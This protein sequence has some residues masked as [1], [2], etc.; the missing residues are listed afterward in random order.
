MDLVFFVLLVG[1]LVLVHELGHFVAARAFGVKVLTFSLG[2]GPALLRIRGRE[3]TYQLGLL[4]FGGF[5]RLLQQPERRDEAVLPPEEAA[6]TYE[7]RS[8][9]Q[10][11]LI[12]LAGPTMNVLVPLFL[13]FAV[14]LEPGRQLAPNVG[15]VVAGSPAEGLLRPGDRVLSIDGREVFTFAEVQARIAAGAGRKLAFTVARSVEGQAGEQV[16]T[17]AVTP[18]SVSETRELGVVAV[19]G[20]LGIGPAPLAAA[21]GVY[22]PGSPAHRAGLRTFDVITHVG[23]VATPR[24]VDLERRLRDNRGV[25]VPVNY[26]RPRVLP[27]PA[28]APLLDLAVH[29]PGVAMLAPEPSDGTTEL[30]GLRRAGIE[31]T[32]LYLASV[33]EGSSEWLAGLRPGDRV[34]TLD[35]AQVL[36]WNA[37][38]EDLIAGGDR[39]RELGFARDGRAMTGLLR[40]RKEEWTDPGGEHVERFVF[41]STHWAPTLPAPLIDEPAPVRRAA[42]MAVRETVHVVR[43]IATSAVNLVQGKLTVRSLSGPLSI[44]DVAGRAGA[45]GTRDFLWVMALISI[46][47][48][49][50]NLLPIPTLDGGQLLYLAFERVAG[51]PIPIRVREVLSFV[52][53]LFLLAIMA[54]ALRNDLLQRRS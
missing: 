36:S 38:V 31:S 6:R 10:R 28:E 44:Y 1:A 8:I 51:R 53:L 32:D 17:V 47:L 37:L 41:R 4:P 23:G 16:V 29:E 15:V 48:G 54:I 21:I 20:R 11:A 46:N 34:R 26:L 35:G 40:V 45:R 25:A 5:V 33:P 42:R 18:R 39:T 19:V 43:F 12:A 27:F 52:G 24:F 50:L 9:L 30:D 7:S 14:F 3:T 13:F 2:F 49:I 22:G